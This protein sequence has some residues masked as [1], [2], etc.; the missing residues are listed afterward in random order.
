[1]AAKDW[2]KTYVQVS[3]THLN[4][5]KIVDLTAAKFSNRERDKTVLKP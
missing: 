4:K 2:I 1:M 5:Y 3:F